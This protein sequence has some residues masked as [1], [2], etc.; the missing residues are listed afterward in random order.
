MRFFT[1]ATA[2]GPVSARATIPALSLA[3]A[4]ESLARLLYGASES[5]N[6]PGTVP[7]FYYDGLS[8]DFH[9]SPGVVAD[10]ANWGEG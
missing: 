8:V 4:K 9:I 3:E 10:D 2:D 6:P 7:L 5:G 1:F